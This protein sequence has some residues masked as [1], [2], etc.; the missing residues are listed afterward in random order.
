MTLTPG[1]AILII[2]FAWFALGKIIMHL[3]DLHNWKQ[4]MKYRRQVPHAT[5]P[6]NKPKFFNHK[7]K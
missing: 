5:A 6:P 7:I 3:F 4:D 1:L 2:V